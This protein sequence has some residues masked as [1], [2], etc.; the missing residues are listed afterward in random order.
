MDSS[1][2]RISDLPENNIQYSTNIGGPPSQVGMGPASVGMGPP[3]AIT[4]SQSKGFDTAVNYIPINVH[5]NPYGISAQNPIMP[6]PQ[7]P[8]VQQI[9]QVQQLENFTQ[10]PHYQIPETHNQLSEQQ[11]MELQNMKHLRLP[12]RD[13]PHDTAGYSY[14]EQVQPNYIPKKNVSSDFVRDY[15]HITEKNIREH[16][17]KKYRES[18]IDNFFNEFQTPI[19]IMILFFLFQLPIVNTMIFKKFSFLSLHNMDGN[20]NIYGLVMKS[21]LFGALYYSIQKITTFIVE[22]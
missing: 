21:F 20:F 10:R 8:N 11:Q 6:I 15:E 22:F 12:S 4:M 2:T 13:I 9:Q 5:P 17:Q 1:T 18:R 3:Q 14:D 7:Q 19:F 16:E